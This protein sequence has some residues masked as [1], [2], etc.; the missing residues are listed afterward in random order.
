MYKLILA[1]GSPRRREILENVGLNFEV[2]ISQSEEI[3]Q[4]TEPDR[5]VMSLSEHKTHE[6]ASNLPKEK[7]PVIVLGADTMVF[8]KKHA[9]GKPKDKED[10]KR[11]LRA[12]SGDVHEVMTGVNLLIIEEGNIKKEI[13]FAS[14]T[15]VFVDTLSEQE[16]EDYVATGEPMDKAGAYAIQGKFS[17]YVRKIEG[18]YFNVVGLPIADIWRSLKNEHIEFRDID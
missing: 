13:R 12:I 11:M 16:I 17:V 4:E 5:L 8:H 18:D 1:S 10:A 3:S 2:M 7:E 15:K 6:I 14:T 9:L